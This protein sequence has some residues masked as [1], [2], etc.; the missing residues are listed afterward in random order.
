MK[1]SIKKFDVA[2]DVKNNGIEF[3][4]HGNDGA[5]RGDCY[6]TKTGLIWCEGKKPRKNGVNVSWDEFIEWMN[7]DD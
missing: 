6:V 7:S 1:V 5:F 4:V 2:M 3:Q